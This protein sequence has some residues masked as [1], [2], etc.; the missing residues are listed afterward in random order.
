MD[1]VDV[2]DT[3]RDR[4]GVLESV[5]VTSGEAERDVQ[6]EALGVTDGETLALG[7]AVGDV[8]GDTD[9]D[10]A[11]Q[12]MRMRLPAHS[13]TKTQPVTGEMAAPPAW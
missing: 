13:A 7:D 9:G 5:L 8:D 4:E 1:A 2:L 6:S 11:W 12:T 3:D 10:G